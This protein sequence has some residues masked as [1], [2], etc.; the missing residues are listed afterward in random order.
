[1]TVF[2]ILS[3]CKLFGK[4]LCNTFEGTSEIKSNRK[5]TYNRLY[6]TLS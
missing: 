6:Q 4:K 3:L 5:D 1:M 2:L